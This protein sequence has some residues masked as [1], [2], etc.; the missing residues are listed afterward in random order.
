MRSVKFWLIAAF[1]T[2]PAFGLMLRP[3]IYTMHDPHLFRVQ[4]FDQCFRSGSF[5]CRWAADSG[6]GYGEPLFNFYAQLPYWLT[7]TGR[8]LGL[9][10]IDST[11]TVFILSLVASAVAMYFLSRRYFGNY[12]GLVSAAV[13]VYAPYRAVDVWVRGALPE[14]LAFVFYP[15]IL[16]ALDKYLET[17]KTSHLIL[18]AYLAAALMTT[19]NL[20]FLMFS[21]FLLAFWLFRSL[22]NRSFSSLTGLIPAGF[23]V[24]ALSAYYLLPVIFEGHLVT[25]DTTVQAYY[26][27]RIH[28]T[29]L[30]ELFISRYWGYGASLWA[31]KFLSVSVG[32]FQW[33]LPLLLL[34]VCW[35]K[36]KTLVKAEFLQFGFFVLAGFAAL[37]LTHGKSSIIWNHLDFMKFIQFP[38]RFLTIA[39]FFLSL[40][41]GF[42]CRLFPRLAGRLAPGLIIIAMLVNVAFFRPDIWRTIGDADLVSGPLWDEGRS[43]SLTDFWPVSAAAIPTDF[44]PVNPE[45]AAGSGTVHSVTRSAVSAVYELTVSSTSAQVIFPTTYFPGWV[46]TDNGWKLVLQP[47]GDLSQISTYLTSGPHRIVLNFTDTLPRTAGNIISLLALF[48]TPLWFL[49]KRLG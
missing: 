15:L 7:E 25:L 2:L 22:T 30:K 41:A 14:A 34:P 23:L 21:P 5:P 6:K 3:G 4:Q 20:S 29:T 39:V 35:L 1:L 28:F 45:F 17:K 40:S 13:Y 49:K 31:Q 27:Y 47:A 10:V 38:W 37:F 46:G 33:I 12:G 48:S 18:L 26:D 36:R 9:S 43:S 19:H 44:A 8:L 32:Q 16:L 11:K 24:L 42:A